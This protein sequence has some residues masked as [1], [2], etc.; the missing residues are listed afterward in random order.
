MKAS[1]GNESYSQIRA[2]LGTSTSSPIH[3]SLPPSGPQ[4][5]NQ[6]SETSENGENKTAATPSE[7]ET[8][9]APSSRN[10]PSS[11]NS[12]DSRTSEGGSSDS[13]EPESEGSGSRDTETIGSTNGDTDESGKGCKET[14]SSDKEDK[15][16][17]RKGKWAVRYFRKVS[18]D[19][20]CALVSHVLRFVLGGGRRV[21]IACNTAFQ[22]W[23]FDSSRWSY[24]AIVLGREAKL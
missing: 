20:A 10:T 23:T 11:R 14:T 16:S 18:P 13:D 5:A 6:E 17:L 2:E 21:H 4:S 3:T 12:I 22:C 1:S 15:K 24:L 9:G 19:I 7:K 8:S